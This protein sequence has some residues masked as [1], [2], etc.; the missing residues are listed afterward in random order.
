LKAALVEALRQGKPRRGTRRRTLA[1]SAIVPE[2]LKI[3]Y[4]PE[5]VEARLVPGH[6]V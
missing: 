5:E 2:S 6:W 1:G 3:I 4:R